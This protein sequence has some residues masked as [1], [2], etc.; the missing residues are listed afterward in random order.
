[1]NEEQPQRRI[2]AVKLIT[3]KIG[4]ELVLHTA[5]TGVVVVGVKDGE[6]QLTIEEGYPQD[7]LN[8]EGQTDNDS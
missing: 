7:L 6:V 8:G 5:P 2:S 4:E 3:V 1:M